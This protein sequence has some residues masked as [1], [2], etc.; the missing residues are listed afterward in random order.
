MHAVSSQG[1]RQIMQ[2][3]R[4]HAPVEHIDSPRG[5]E[6]YFEEIRSLARDMAASAAAL[7]ATA[8]GLGLNAQ[9]KD[10]YLNLAKKL[11]DEAAA[12]GQGPLS[13]VEQAEQQIATVYSTCNA[14]HSLFRAER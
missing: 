2:K 3:M 10:V 5:R 13:N 7:P 6:R 14:C 9:E 4:Y 12:L 11:S 1:V 8:D